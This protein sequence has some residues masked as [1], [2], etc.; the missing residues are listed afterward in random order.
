MEKNMMFRK[1]FGALLCLL[2]IGV[3]IFTVNIGLRNQDALPVLVETPVTARQ[4]L[5]QVLDSVCSGDY[6]T[7]GTMIY[8]DLSFGVDSLPED[9]VS[10]MFWNA[11][12]ESLSYTLEGEL[13]TTREGLAQKVRVTGL[14]FSSVTATLR[15]R[16]QHLLEQRVA[17]AEDMSEIYDENN[18]YREE[19]VMSVL[20]EAAQAALAEDAEYPEKEIIVNVIYR[21]GQWW[22]V[23]DDALLDAVSGGIAG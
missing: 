6:D 2:G 10:L 8:G 5:E 21:Q 23:A 14:D 20:Y 11:F 13:Y 18:E 16:S 12:Q 19:L 1:I 17:D 15:E 22:I 7:A 9:P 3:A 4:R